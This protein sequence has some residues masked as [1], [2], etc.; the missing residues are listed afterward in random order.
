MRKIVFLFVFMFA[1]MAANAQFEEG[2]WIVGS[3]VTGLDLS[4]AGSSD[5]NLGTKNHFGFQAEAGYFLMD[6]LALLGD[7][8]GDW[9]SSADMYQLGAKARYYFD[10]VGFYAGTGLLLRSMQIKHGSDTTDFALTFEGGY[11]YF[12]SRTV[13]IEPGL[14]Y[15]LS[16]SDNDWSRFGLKIG[17]SLYF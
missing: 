4:F 15:H 11:T 5:N 9:S 13:A 7:L 17:F 12:L 8:G 3:S 1:T 2:K 10:K 6:N 16:L 14:Y